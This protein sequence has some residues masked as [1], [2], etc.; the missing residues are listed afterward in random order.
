MRR[1]KKSFLLYFSNI[2]K[3]GRCTHIKGWY[4]M[5]ILRRRRK[6]KRKRRRIYLTICIRYK[7]G[8]SQNFPFVGKHVFY[9]TTESRVFLRDLP[10]KSVELALATVGP[11]KRA[12]PSRTA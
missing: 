8:L 10:E 5:I 9:S 12:G 2:Y 6:Q 4:F 11:G 1:R 3:K 7:I